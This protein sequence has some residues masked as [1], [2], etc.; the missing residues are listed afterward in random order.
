MGLLIENLL[1]LLFDRKLKGVTRKQLS[2]PNKV[3]RHRAKKKLVDNIFLKDFKEP[4]LSSLKKLYIFTLLRLKQLDSKIE[5]GE[6]LLKEALKNE[7]YLI[8][9]EV[10]QILL[11][12][13]VETEH[14]K[15]YQDLSFKL[16]SYITQ[17]HKIIANYCEVV[18]G[19][20]LIKIEPNTKRGKFYQLFAEVVYWEQRNHTKMLL[21]CE[22]G[23]KA[24][25]GEKGEL[26]FLIKSF[27]PLIRYGNS[28]KNIIRYIQIEKGINKLNGYCYHAIYWN[29]QADYPQAV[30]L[31]QAALQIAKTPAI[32]ELLQIINAWANLM[33][34]REGFKFSKFLND[35]SIFTKQ[36][37]NENAG[38][39]L[40]KVLSWIKKDE[41]G[42]VIDA[43]IS[44]KRYTRRY[45]TG[46]MMIMFDLIFLL[47]KRS[48]APMESEVAEIAAKLG[49]FSPLEIN[50]E[51][52]PFGVLVERF[53]R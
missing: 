5:Y 36:K 40:L 10:S 19:G 4:E 39:I 11:L 41:T 27:I 32:V 8:A 31:C 52:V 50:V 22:K 7:N 17:E 12:Y 35:L 29:Y 14:R 45:V 9:F 6:S 20:E 1:K 26:H 24:F 37:S 13:S 21:S 43:E 16:L 33:L 28:D 49:D 30:Q 3:I 23:I 44:L 25:P 46:R 51:V 53:F 47:I 48:F 38:L 18:K 34:D 2:S 42:K 15:K